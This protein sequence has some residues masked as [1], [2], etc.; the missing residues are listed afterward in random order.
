MK[1][2]MVYDPVKDKLLVNRDVI[3]NEKKA[4]NWE[5]SDSRHN[6]E[7]MIP[8]IF[9]VQYSDTVPGLTIGPEEGFAGSEPVD[10]EPPSPVV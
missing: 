8:D 9:T 4:W 2:Y 7:A 10:G 5:G 6:S 1:G 3:F